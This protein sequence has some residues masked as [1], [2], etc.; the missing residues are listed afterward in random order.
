[1]FDRDIDNHLGTQG[2]QLLN[3]DRYAKDGNGDAFGSRSWL[4]ANALKPNDLL[5]ISMS[6]PEIFGD[7]LHRFLM[8]GSRRMGC[9]NAVCEDQML[10]ENRVELTRERDAF[11]V[12]RARVSYRVSA[13][14][15]RLAAQAGDEGLRIMKAAGAREAWHG[16]T[17]PMHI[18][19]GTLM[20]RDADT[21][22]SN[23]DAQT[24]EIANL[25]IG[26]SGL[27]P[28]TSAVNPT[29][30]VHALALKSARFIERHFAALAV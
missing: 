15:R 22:V 17:N 10:P 8:E 3:Q 2:G 5:G 23:A 16:P 13:D 4:I 30:T 1:M 26:G 6:R 12:P 21:S 24:H 18:M 19:G 28:S 7:A 14:A 27:F 25:L 11:G 9:M 20:G 29:F